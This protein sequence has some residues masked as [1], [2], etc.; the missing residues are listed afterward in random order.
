M[1]EPI[2]MP[3]LG[4][5]T[6]EGTLVSWL[7][8]SGTPVEVAEPVAQIESE[9]AIVEIVAPATGVLAHVAVAG[10]LVKEQGLLGYI[11]ADGEQPP[12]DDATDALGPQVNS[13][14]AQSTSAAGTS[15]PSVSAPSSG[16]S[17]RASP[18]A[19]KLAA[20]YGIN[21][22]EIKGTGPGGRIVEADV[23]AAVTAKG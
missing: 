2:V 3:S 21:L 8:A 13:A 16:N 9:K 7:I 4:M 17:V 23:R 11:L 22:M 18:I 20:R 1:A 15:A 19:R 12:V 5:Y 14:A 6:A 10:S